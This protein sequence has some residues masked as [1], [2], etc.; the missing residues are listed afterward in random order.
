MTAKRNGLVIDA[1]R[2]DD[3]QV[4][5]IEQARAFL[6]YPLITLCCVVT[7]GY[8]GVLEARLVGLQSYSGIPDK[9]IR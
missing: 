9:N 2:G 4:F 3:M 8:G 5:P 1:T 6:A 7:I